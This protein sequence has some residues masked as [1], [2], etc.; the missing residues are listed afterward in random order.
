LLSFSAGAF[1]LLLLGFTAPFWFSG[2]AAARRAAAA[3]E[4]AAHE[5][6][7]KQPSLSTASDDNGANPY[8]EPIETVPSVPQLSARHDQ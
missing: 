1:V 8:T 6:A 7:A 4:V 2:R 5:A 3:E